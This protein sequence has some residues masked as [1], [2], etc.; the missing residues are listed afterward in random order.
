VHDTHHGDA[1]VGRTELTMQ[2]ELSR[3]GEDGMT[4]TSFPVSERS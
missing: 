2:G 3:K 1:H 4:T